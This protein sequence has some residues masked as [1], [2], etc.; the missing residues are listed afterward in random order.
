MNAELQGKIA[1][2]AFREEHHL[3]V[4]PLGDLVALIEQ[5]TGHDVAVLDAGPHEHGLTMR[6][7]RRDA[8]FIAVTRTRHPMRQR[9]SLA[10][11]LAHVYFKDWGKWNEGGDLSARSMPE[12]RADAF[13]R[14]LLVPEAGLMEFV[15]TRSDLTLADLSA[16]VQRFLVSPPI[17]TIALH[18]CRFI[19][20]ST[21]DTWMKYTTPNLA[22]RF[23]WID[24]YQS[25][26]RSADRTRA[27]QRLL[28]RAVRGYQEGVVGPQTV[29]TLRGVSAKEVLDEFEAAGIVQEDH[30][31]PWAS[32]ADLPPVDVDL[33]DLEDEDP[34]GSV[35]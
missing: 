4:Q 15:G 16:V 19:D 33:S 25:L 35:A 27:P 11:E 2:A 30:P 12:I 34:G 14:H 6:D 3:G 8:V 9:S 28:A 18:Q 32:A 13:S 24:Q 29:A 21:K 26:Q 7:P 23:G 17:A 5:T 10:H 22:T 1:A 20:R 31:T